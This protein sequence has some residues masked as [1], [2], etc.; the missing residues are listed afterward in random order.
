MNKKLKKWR[1]LYALCVAMLLTVSVM[2]CGSGQTQPTQTEPAVS[3]ENDGTLGDSKVEIGDFL[4][5]KTYEGKDAIV[6]N[7][8]FTNNSD[9]AKSYMSALMST[10]YQDG[11]ELSTAIIIDDTVYD[12]DSQMKELKKGAS[13]N[14]QVAYELSNITSDVEFEVEE[15]LSFSNSKLEKTFVISE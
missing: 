6:I 1:K 15:F 10:A 3:Q 8:N 13:I 5:T 2:G 9:D 7:M 14:V 12:S 11:V 4:L